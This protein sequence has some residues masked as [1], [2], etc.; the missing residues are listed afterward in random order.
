[1]NSNTLAIGNFGTIIHE[2]GNNFIIKEIEENR[3]FHVELFYLSI[4]KDCPNICQIIDYNI[5]A[6]QI[7]MVKYDYDLYQL[8]KLISF[9]KKIELVKDIITHVFIGL[10]E[11]HSRG[12]THCDIRDENIFCNY[13]FENNKIE[14]FVSDFSLTSIRTLDYC[15]I[16][17]Y[18]NEYEEE[19]FNKNTQTKLDIWCIFDVIKSFLDIRKDDSKFSKLCEILIAFYTED[20]NKRFGFKL[21]K[22]IFMNSGDISNVIKEYLPSDFS[23]YIEKII[24]FNGYCEDVK[25]ENTNLIEI[26]KKLVQSFDFPKLDI[27]EIFG[28]EFEESIKS[29]NE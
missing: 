8:S 26:Y 25:L 2:K 12:I 7:K 15:A 17:D 27:N 24:A 18:P 11:M 1:M 21:S 23:D 10:R 19:D 20:K 6:N 9:D 29:L 28:F 22:P 13:D 5:S 3:I 14:C 4:F 16:D